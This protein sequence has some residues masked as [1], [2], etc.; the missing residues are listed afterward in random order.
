MFGAGCLFFA[1]LVLECLSGGGGGG[2]GGGGANSLTGAGGGG[3]GGGISLISTGGGGGGGGGGV[4]F[5]FDWAINCP[6]IRM[7]VIIVKIFFI[8]KFF[9]EMPP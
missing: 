4:A 6:A 9:A 7:A 5:L 3:G 1:L 8:F 2:G